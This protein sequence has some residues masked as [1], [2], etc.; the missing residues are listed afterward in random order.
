VNALRFVAYALGGLVV[1]GAVGYALG[2]RTVSDRR[3][4]WLTAAGLIAACVVADY[5]GV[6]L[7]AEWLR[8]GAVCAMAGALTG[9]KYGGMQEVRVWESPSAPPAAENDDAPPPE[10]S[11]AS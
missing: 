6:V 1:G 5:F 8:T 11:G 4:F 9:L 2:R 7:G 10:D 3:G